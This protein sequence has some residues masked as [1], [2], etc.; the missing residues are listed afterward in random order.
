VRGGNRDWQDNYRRHQVLG[1]FSHFK[2]GWLGSHQFKGGGEVFLTNET[3]IWRRSYAGDVLHITRGGQPAEVY[4]FGTPS[5]SESGLWTYSA[6]ANDSWRPHRRITLNLGA[7]LDRYLVF[8]PE[9]VHPAGRFNPSL[10][11]F[12]AVDEVIAWNVLVPRAGVTYDL[13]GDGRTVTKVSYG[14]YALAPGNVVGFNAN[15]NSNQ[16]WRRYAW[17]DANG[18][19]LWEAGEE[20]RL[21]GSRG[22]VAVESLDPAL[23]L[24]RVTEAAAWIERELPAG[25]GL[26]T[27]VVWRDASNYF[28]RV[29]VNRPFGAFSVPVSIAD[30]G[31]DGLVGTADDGSPIPGRDLARTVAVLAPVSEVRNVAGAGSRHWTWEIEAHRR[32]GGRWSLMA[33]F[34]HVWNG[35]QANAY[36]GQVVRQNPYPVT[37]NDQI[38]AGSDGRYDFRTWTAKVHGTFDAPWGVRVAPRLRHQSGQP[39]GR[40]FVTRL[41]YGTV[42]VLAEPMGTRRMDNVTLLD[43]RFEKGFRLPEGRRFAAFVDVFNLFNANPEQNVNW[44]SGNTFL[45]PLAIVPPRILRLGTRL[46]W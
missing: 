27:G 38:N 4:L 24:P 5:Q 6:Y 10:Q 26:R 40:T 30:P 17:T 9:Q 14:R 28:M 8:L 11:T 36:G 7:R 13:A 20:G 42:R 22:G 25:I 12:A 44:S 2:D 39:F 37:P 35:D 15:P 46:D 3:E 19:G 29:S 32:H 34:A 1:S 41:E 33:G 45:Q 21:L 43:V 18:S 16:W 23:E 31:P